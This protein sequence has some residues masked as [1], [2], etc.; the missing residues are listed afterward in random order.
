MKQSDKWASLTQ[1]DRPPPEACW[2]CGSDLV[3]VASTC[4]VVADR[5]APVCPECGAA[6]DSQ[7]R[8][9]QP[10]RFSAN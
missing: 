2:R 9:P 10:A 7:T 5:L 3:P 6:Q 4:V 1:T 8:S